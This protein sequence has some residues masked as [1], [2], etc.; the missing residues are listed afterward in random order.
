M[1]ILKKIV[2][3]LEYRTKVHTQ[4]IIGVVFLIVYVVLLVLL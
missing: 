4:V 1:K 2:N 3:D